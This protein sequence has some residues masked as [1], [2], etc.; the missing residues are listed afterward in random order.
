[1]QLFNQAVQTIEP[2]HQMDAQKKS[3]NDKAPLKSLTATAGTVQSLGT[4]GQN[5]VSTNGT[6]QQDSATNKRNLLQIRKTDNNT[7]FAQ[8]STAK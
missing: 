8:N 6:K 3:D 5:S 4:N 1:M 2:Q 7:S